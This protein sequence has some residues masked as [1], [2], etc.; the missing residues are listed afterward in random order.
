MNVNINGSAPNTGN[1]GRQ[2][3]PYNTSDFNFI[4][5]FGD[6]TYH[7][8]HTD[9]K[10]RFGGSIIG[11]AYTWSKAIDNDNGDNGDGT[12]FRAYPVSY[13]LNKQLAGFDRK[14]TFHV[15]SRLPVSVRQR[16]Q[17]SQPRRDCPDRRRIPDQ[18]HPQPV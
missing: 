14:H 2:L 12:L 17:A 9:L 1:A 11:V 4:E 10:K 8:L 16:A 3:Y 18:R 13:A 6:M 5:P 7:G 15:L